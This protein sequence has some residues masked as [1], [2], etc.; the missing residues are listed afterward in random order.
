MEI[1]ESCFFYKCNPKLNNLCKKAD[2]QKSCFMTTHKE[3]SKDGKKYFYDKGVLSVY[4]EKAEGEIN[5]QL[6]NYTDAHDAENE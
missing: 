4:P 2:C 6:S 3:F 1:H 5:G